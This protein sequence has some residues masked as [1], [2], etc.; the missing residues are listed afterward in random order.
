MK[1]ISLEVDILGEPVCF[2]IKVVDRPA[3]LSGI[4]PLARNLSTK[5]ALVTLDRLSAK[6]QC[7]PCRK[8]C[9]ACCS[10]LV[11]LSV[12]EA[13]RLAEEL[14]AMPANESKPLI[15]SS[16]ETTRKILNN[17]P[18]DFELSRKEDSGDAFQSQEI[19]DWYA[20][21][22]LPCPF[23]SD[24][25]CVPYEHRPIACREH[26]VTGSAKLCDLT[27]TDKADVVKMPISVF[28]CLGRL[29]AEL[30]K[31]DVEAVMLPLTLLWVQ[32]NVER[33]ERTWPAP[34]MVERF[35]EIIQTAAE[36][37]APAA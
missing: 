23:L 3:R 32:E 37:C 12:P 34:T 21:L 28:E 9:S 15:Q 6:G 2:D 35:V 18:A 33:S 10:Y 30:E 31:S 4:V 14:S 25:L 17:M 26:M 36:A 8:G 20:G 16:I 11:P 13:F 24:G 7:V 1:R 19:G 22:K 27:S 29:T 5:M